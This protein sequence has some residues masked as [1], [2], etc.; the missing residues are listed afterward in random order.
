MRIQL[1]NGK[2]KSGGGRV[3]YIDIIEKERLYLLLAYPKSKQSNL[4]DE[5]KKMVRKIAEM[6][7]RE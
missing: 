7:K 1:N 4:T 3:I 5:Q 6:I 2:G